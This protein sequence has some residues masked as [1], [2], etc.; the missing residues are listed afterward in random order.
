MSSD[1]SFLPPRD[2]WANPRS[3]ESKLLCIPD[4]I[5]FPANIQSILEESRK[6]SSNPN[7]LSWKEVVCAGPDNSDPPVEKQNTKEGDDASRSESLKQSNVNQVRAT[8][9]LI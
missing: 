5:P 8:S 7:I 2:P 1:P 4:D 3:P 9:S 6:R